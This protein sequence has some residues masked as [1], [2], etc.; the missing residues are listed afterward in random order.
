MV[1][2]SHFNFERH[3]VSDITTRFM[4]PVRVRRAQ[5]CG[6]LYLCRVSR[7]A[8]AANN[9]NNGV[10]NDRDTGRTHGTAIIPLKW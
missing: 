8:H 5:F 7:P 9:G 2:V 6:S 3:A 4:W 1:S 10:E